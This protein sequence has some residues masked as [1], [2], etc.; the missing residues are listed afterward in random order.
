MSS[1]SHGAACVKDWRLCSLVYE[2]DIPRPKRSRL[3]LTQLFNQDQERDR[4][5]MNMVVTR[6][7]SSW[8]CIGN[9][10]HEHAVCK[11]RHTR[12]FQ[13]HSTRY[14]GGQRCC[15]HATDQ[16][17]RSGNTNHF[18]RLIHLLQP[19]AIVGIG[20]TAQGITPP[21]RR[22]LDVFF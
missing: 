10:K 4:R 2:Q 6:R 21:E 20:I 12:H 3:L 13:M 16:Q 15:T 22:M 7:C 17:P 1:R 8:A 9:T 18:T 14:N 11:P 19:P 5:T